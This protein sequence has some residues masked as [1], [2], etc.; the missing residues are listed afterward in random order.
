MQLVR[1]SEKGSAPVLGQILNS[2][3]VPAEGGFLTPPSIKFQITDR[4]KAVLLLLTSIILV[5][6]SISVLSP[7]LSSVREAELPPFGKELLTRLIV[8]TQE[9]MTAPYRLLDVP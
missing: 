6:M 2:N 4:S 5:L 8:R 1:H 3:V 7:F 9:L